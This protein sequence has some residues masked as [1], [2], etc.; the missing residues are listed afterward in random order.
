VFWHTLSGKKFVTYKDIAK[1][2][3][4]KSSVTYV[5]D[6]VSV[7]TPK[8]TAAINSWL[9]SIGHEEIRSAYW[10]DETLVQLLLNYH[11][12]EAIALWLITFI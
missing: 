6:K 3:G 7:A 5:K 8:N 1:L 10:I 12:L 4:D 11:E 9:R 2:F